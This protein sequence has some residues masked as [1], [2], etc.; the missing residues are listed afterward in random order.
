ML[1]CSLADNYQ[2]FELTSYFLH[3]QDGTAEDEDGRS[4]ETLVPMC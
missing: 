4:Y 1:L 3:L 2:G